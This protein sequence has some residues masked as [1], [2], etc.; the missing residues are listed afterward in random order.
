MQ[1]VTGGGGGDCV[2]LAKPDL[3]NAY[4]AIR[5]PLLWGGIFVVKGGSGRKFHYA[6]L[7]FG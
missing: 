1:S 5:L 3:Q 4:W 7:P 2:F 6:R